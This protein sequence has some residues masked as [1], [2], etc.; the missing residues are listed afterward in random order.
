ML[1]RQDEGPAHLR[2]ASGEEHNQFSHSHDSGS[3]SST[4]L[5]WQGARVEEGIS[6]LPK[7]PHGRQA[8]RPALLH[9][10]SQ[11][12]LTHAPCHQGQLCCAAQVQREFSRVLRQVRGRDSSPSLVTPQEG[13]LSCLPLAVEAKGRGRDLSLPEAQQ[14]SPILIPSPATPTSRATST[15]QRS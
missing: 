13:K 5:R 12:Q 4:C 15:V 3:S 1:P 7:M 9:S 2:V 6:P 10:H 8:E 11:G 14:S